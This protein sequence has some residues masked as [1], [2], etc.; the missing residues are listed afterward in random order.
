MENLA[1]KEEHES[2]KDPWHFK[3]SR[4]ENKKKDFTNCKYL[5]LY[6]I[7]YFIKNKL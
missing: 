4:V 2:P 6:K 5:F 7:E 1:V 3:S